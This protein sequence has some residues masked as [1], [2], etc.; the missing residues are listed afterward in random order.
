MNLAR[1]LAE[2]LKDNIFGWKLCY[3][4]TDDGWNA[5]DFH[6]KCDDVGPS[7]T[8]V[9]CGISVFGGFTD[10]SWKGKRTFSAK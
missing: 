1:Q 4:A 9:K 7:V 3:R 5:R 10:E 2:W 6:R 8:L